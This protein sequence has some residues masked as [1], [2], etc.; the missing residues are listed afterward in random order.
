MHSSLFIK[1]GGFS[2]IHNLIE[3]FYEKLLDSKVV[4]SYFENS[5]MATLIE[6]QSHFISSLLGG[7]ISYTDE[8]LQAVHCHLN[9]KEDVWHEVMTLL[10]LALVEFEMER[11][12]LEMILNKLSAKKGMFLC[13]QS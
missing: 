7:P 2:S 5:N 3:N 10:E 13:S 12:D 1:Y 4:G 6:H 9:I 11:V 8:H